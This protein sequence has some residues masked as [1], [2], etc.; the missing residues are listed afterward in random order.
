MVNFAI[1][2]TNTKYG[3]LTLICLKTWYQENQTKICTPPRIIFKFEKFET[4]LG[5]VTKILEVSFGTLEDLKDKGHIFC[6]FL[7]GI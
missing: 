4:N 6:V 1:L 7:A 5:K 2:K 3:A